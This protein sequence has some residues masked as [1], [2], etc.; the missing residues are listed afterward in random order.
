MLVNIKRLLELLQH[1]N[2]NVRN[3]SIKALETFYKGSSGIIS[4]IIRAIDKYPGDSLS[5]VARISLFIPNDDEISELIRLFNET[6]PDRDD[7]SMNRFFHIQQSLLH[8]PIQ[9]LISNE[10]IIRFNKDLSHSLDIALHK[11][12]LKSQDP[13]YLWDTLKEICDRFKEKSLD[14]DASQNGWSITKGL[15]RH[16]EKI[17]HKIVM[18]LSQETE[19]NYHFEEFLVSLAGDL[20]IEECAPF[21]FKLLKETD[22]MHSVHDR[23]IQSLGKIG[24]RNVVNTIEEDWHIKKLR[25]D[26][27]SILR[28]IPFDYSEELLIRCLYQE[29][30]EEIKTF[31]CD[32]LCDIFSLKGAEKVLNII[33]NK[34]YNPQIS[35]L[36]DYVV[37]VF[38]YHGEEV[39]DIEGIQQKQDEYIKSHWKSDPLYRVSKRLRNT[40]DIFQKNYEKA[41]ARKKKEQ[42]KQKKK[43]IIKMKKKKKKKK[44]K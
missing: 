44:K 32:A 3:Q 39:N 35:H 23:C 20:K 17:K 43:N 16:K 6:D 27:S 26:Y 2:P 14:Q 4:H 22:F 10:K 12:K 29:K 11:E 9:I 5:L 37:P 38:I 18:Y 8:F 42:R 36:L 41:K 7:Q 25:A 33:K 19:N 1:E 30:D 15:L 40:F 34:E 24:G 31:L 13:D 21:L 28:F